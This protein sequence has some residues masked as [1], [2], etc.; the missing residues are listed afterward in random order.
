VVGR[1][2][3]GSERLPHELGALRVDCGP[4][5]FE[6]IERVGRLRSGG[7]VRQRTQFLLRHEPGDFRGHA[8]ELA[9][10]GGPARLVHRIRRIELHLGELVVSVE[11]LGRKLAQL[12]VGLPS[13]HRIGPSLTAALI[14]ASELAGWRV[15][16]IS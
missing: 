9:D 13:F 4:R 14:Q 8:V 1:E 6:G 10:R 15:A 2:P 12:L 16:A 11:D 5:P 7:V 3:L